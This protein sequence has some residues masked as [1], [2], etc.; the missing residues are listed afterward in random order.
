MEINQLQCFQKVARCGSIAK[1]SQELFM[2]QS[3]LSRVVSRLESS[4]GYSL[5]ERKNGRIFLN[6][7]GKKFLEYVDIALSQLDEGLKAI[8]MD[9]A[10]TLHILI[11]PSILDMCIP[12]VSRVS[13]G[14]ADAAYEIIEMPTGDR[15]LPP[16][17]IIISVSHAERD[18]LYIPS[19][20]EKWCLICS[21]KHPFSGL[22]RI[23][24]AELAQTRLVFGGT[25]TDLEFIQQKYSALDLVPSFLS[26]IPND[27]QYRVNLANLVGSGKAVLLAPYDY[28]C[29]CWLRDRDTLLVCRP[30]EGCDFS[31]PI[32]LNVNPRSIF[33]DLTQRFANALAVGI[34]QHLREVDAIVG[35]LFAV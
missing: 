2:T 32:Y 25:S 30:L 4:I 3:A 16:S 11:H 17:E 9:A 18:P 1:A 35:R 8:S 21:R 7:R 6:G 27:P 15:I 23:T 12:I 33:P 10:Y 13:S 28:Y 14:F 19:S 22:S 5:F 24:G 31:R 20:T 29:S 26:C 34:D